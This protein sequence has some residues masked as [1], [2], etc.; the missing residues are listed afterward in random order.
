MRLL[1][2]TRKYLLEIFR[3]WQLVLMILLLPVVFLFITYFSYP[4]ALIQ[5]YPIHFQA[6]PEETSQSLETLNNLKAAQYANGLPIYAVDQSLL[7]T[8]EIDTRIQSK[9]LVLAISVDT[10]S[11]P[12]AISILGD[13]LSPAYYQAVNALQPQWLGN[14]TPQL[15]QTSITPLYAHGP[16]SNFE[17]YAP[18]M[19]VFAILLMI[20]QT[21]MLITREIKSGTIRR[22]QLSGTKSAA[23]VGGITLAQ[24]CIAFLQ[25]IVIGG[26]SL[27]LGFHLQGSLWFA[28]LNAVLLALASIAQG[29]ITGCFLENDTQAATIGATIAMLQ[30]F[31]SGAF[32]EMPSLTLFHIGI[33]SFNLFDIFPATYSMQLFNLTL[34]YGAGWDVLQYRFILLSILTLLTFIAAVIIYQKKRLQ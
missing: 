2:V 9:E 18:G 10:Q 16:V 25:F 26:I 14:Q 27:M 13:P 8:D 1:A 12:P 29:I 22:Y 21:S 17:V 28:L 20:M 7:S 5:T 3:E 11:Q 34:S 30:V 4:G 24:L 31:L 15:L 6:L 19:I 33:H 23:I 32:F